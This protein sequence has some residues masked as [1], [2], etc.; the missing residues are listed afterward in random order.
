MTSLS[1]S[2]PQPV[3]S[4]LVTA[5][6][7][8]WIERPQSMWI[9]FSILAALVWLPRLIL[10]SFWVD[11][12]GTFWMAHDGLIAAVQKTWHWPGQSVL[13]SAIASL[14]CLNS[15]P[16][17][18]FAL[19][20]PTVLGMLAAGYFLYRLAESAIGKGAGLPAVAIFAFNPTTVVLGTEARPYGLA[21][22]AAAASTWF[23]YRY[24]ETNSRKDLAGYIAGSTLIVYFHYFFAVV[25]CVHLVY[26][27][28][29]SWIA[30]LP[31]RWSRIIAA[32]IAVG[33]LALPLLPHMLL[34]AREAHTFQYSRKP[35]VLELVE[36]VLPMLLAFGLL[37]SALVVQF[38]F[39]GM[40]RRAVSL[41][42]PDTVLVVMLWLFGPA[43]LFSL[44][45]A[46]SGNFFFDRYFGYALLG[47]ALVLGYAGWSVFQS[48][49]ARVWVLLAAFLSTA[50]PLAIA[51][52][53]HP[54]QTDL[55]PMLNVIRAESSRG[56][57][58]PVFFSSPLP[59][60]NFLNWKGGVAKTYLYAP[61]VAYPIPNRFFPLPYL[62][63]DDAKQYISN[64]IESQLAH[65]HEVIF[66][67]H[68][69]NF[70]VWVPWMMA[71]MQE[72]GFTGEVEQ[73]NSAYTVVIFRR[74]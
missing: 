33:V 61:F 47:E 13:Y 59:E 16:L 35:M 55:A 9:V 42:R 74:P 51:A 60:S 4:S 19:R 30:R 66:V 45:L 25:F 43:L 37:L 24:R 32:W 15:G 12:A 27:L 67:T 26:L 17:R 72:A 50:S 57:L 28:Y 49:A 21:V 44:S 54:G 71:R 29:A 20:I 52:G 64:A 34:I 56:N 14:F 18:E 58:P 7:R 5:R 31:V 3:D 70:S 11:E 41:A 53:F 69:A 48:Q 73:P 38:L 8:A 40:L 36:E 46:V 22:G 23:L 62:P 10:R 65:A 2:L 39:P 1:R 68:H 6:L 63:S